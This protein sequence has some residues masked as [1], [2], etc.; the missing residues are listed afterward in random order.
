MSWTR[1]TIANI[2][3]LAAFLLLPVQLWAADNDKTPKIKAAYIHQFSH[4]VS[5]SDNGDAS[6]TPDALLTICVMGHDR[7]GEY[8]ERLAGH[9]HGS[10]SI[11]VEHLASPSAAHHCEILYIASRSL[12]AVDEIIQGMSRFPVLTV[13]DIPGFVDR[14]GMIGFVLKEDRVR[15]EINLFAAQ[16]ARLRI[17]AKLIEVSLRVI[18]VHANGGGE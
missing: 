7:V 10:Y 17:S 9:S 3:I 8:L 14:G 15:L 12:A 11:G 5:W 6:K 16:R 13:S 4:F 1:P 18:Q 2:C